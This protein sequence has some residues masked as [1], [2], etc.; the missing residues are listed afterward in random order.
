MKGQASNTGGAFTT[1]F[2]PFFPSAPLGS[3]LGGRPVLRPAVF[4]HTTCG[5]SRG[6]QRQQRQLLACSTHS[7]RCCLCRAPYL[8]Q[9]RG[10]RTRAPATALPPRRHVHIITDRSPCARSSSQHQGA[11]REAGP[12]GV[13]VIQ[14]CPP[15][16]KPPAAAA[17]FGS[18]GH[19]G[20]KR[21][22]GAA[23]AASG[24]RAGPAH[25]RGRATAAG[26]PG[27]GTA[28][29]AGACARCCGPSALGDPSV[30]S[31]L[32]GRSTRT[33]RG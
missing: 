30:A 27:P 26:A 8:K 6:R 12:G 17:R 28:G 19:Q 9:P 3:R 16:A 24:A 4:G 31:E 25:A 10:P 22:W 32:E 14:G 18:A 1:C 11:T 20:K 13:T 7:T 21:K 29:A 33:P 2:A 23:A 5:T 15:L